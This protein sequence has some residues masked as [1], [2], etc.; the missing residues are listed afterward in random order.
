MQAK[1]LTRAAVPKASDGAIALPDKPHVK[2][3]QPADGTAQLSLFLPSGANV[4]DPY[5]GGP[6][7]FKTVVDLIESASDHWIDK[8]TANEAKSVVDR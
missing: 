8:L 7:G 3:I 4:P 1:A 6:D 5:Y 2:S